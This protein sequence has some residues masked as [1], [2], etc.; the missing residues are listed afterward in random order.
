ME[1][2]NITKKQEL[3]S[4][5]AK[6]KMDADR[7]AAIAVGVLFIIASVASVASYFFFNSIYGSEY[8]TT[9]SANESNMM[10]GVLLMFIATASIVGIPI[11]M[12][13]VLKK[14]SEVLAHGYIVA[15][16]F[17][18][19]FFVLNTIVLLSIL[20]LSKEYISAGAQSAEY[21][22]ISGSLLLEQFE[23]NSHMVDLPFTLGALILN[24]VLYRSNLIP[25]WLSAWGL[26]AGILWL[27]VAIVGMFSTADLIILAA[28]IGLQEM[29]FA[30]WLLVKGFNTSTVDSES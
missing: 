7:R 13:P 12:Y 14:H 28:P 17:E 5:N 23:W 22:Q 6:P 4:E 18:G 3:G 24:Y 30:G 9:V 8:L 16:M 27:S 15:R 21:F 10:M 11:V 2:I 25:R 26:I 29:V 1:N 20:S 19:L